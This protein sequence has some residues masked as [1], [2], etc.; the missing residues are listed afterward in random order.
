MASEGSVTSQAG[1]VQS[2]PERSPQ[3]ASELNNNVKFM[4]NSRLQE[5][6]IAVDP[7]ELGPI[8]VRISL[9]QNEV[10]VHFSAQH[11]QTRDALEY[12]LPRLKEMLDG[13]GFSLAD[14]GFS[15]QEQAGREA[16]PG[17]G[18]ESYGHSET[19]TDPLN[20]QGSESENDSL[21]PWTGPGRVDYYA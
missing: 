14:A 7:P 1:L 3:W 15:G 10:Q 11:A 20:S 17:S 16:K 13:S 19:E 9:Q 4:I 6:K 8:N 18:G 5:A 2:M 21:S 12:A